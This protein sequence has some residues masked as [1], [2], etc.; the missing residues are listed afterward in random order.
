MPMSKHTGSLPGLLQTLSSCCFRR[1]TSVSMP[2]TVS[3]SSLNWFMWLSFPRSVAS[4]RTDSRSLSILW[5]LII[6]L[7]PRSWVN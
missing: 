5:V 6:H 3:D 4:H 2:F 1:L 7:Q